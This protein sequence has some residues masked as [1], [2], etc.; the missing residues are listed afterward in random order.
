MHLNV[1]LEVVDCS[2]GGDSCGKSVTADTPQER[3]DEEDW[4][5]PTESVRR[6]GNQLTY[7]KRVINF[8]LKEKRL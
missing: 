5:T 6:N 4:P 7:S 8:I 2:V 1:Y 3:S